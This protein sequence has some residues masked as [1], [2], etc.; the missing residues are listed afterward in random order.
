MWERTVS[1]K[2]GDCAESLCRCELFED[3]FSVSFA[4][5]N[6]MNDQP[7]E[8]SFLT[9]WKFWLRSAFFLIVL[10]LLGL[11]LSARQSVATQLAQL[12]AAGLPTNATELNDFY[13]V[14]DGKVDSKRLWLKAVRAVASGNLLERGKDL[15][16]I[17]HGSATVP[18]PG[19]DWEQ[20]SDAE[21]FI[22]GVSQELELIH[23]AADA[24][25]IV[26]FPVDFTQGLNTL[27]VDTQAARDVARLLQ[28]DAYV[29]A[30]QGD[31]NRVLRD[32]LA[33][34]ALSE[35]LQAEPCVISQ[36]I[37]ASVFAM[38]AESAGTML[39]LMDWNDQQLSE[40]QTVVESI[41]FREG[42][43]RA[44]CGE[45]ATFLD[46]LGQFPLGPFRNAATRDALEY[47]QR[48]VESFQ[49]DWLETIECHRL[50]AQE[51]KEDSQTTIGRYKNIAIAMMFP[52]S[53]SFA[54]SGARS[55]SRQ[56]YLLAAICLQRHRLRHGEFPQ[57]LQQ[58][59]VDLLPADIATSGFVDHFTGE[60]LKYLIGDTSV[61]VYTVGQNRTDDGGAIE[62]DE[63]RRQQLDFGIELKITTP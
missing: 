8:A 39:S 56:Q 1:R 19:Q 50:I 61:K 60:S 9:S 51:I 12:R 41:D 5:G 2:R 30:H 37:R 49:N 24:G 29:A 45:R 6:I 20:Y 28:L 23:F 11:W 42:Y 46:S 31:R 27:L 48:S 21:T 33:M 40:L 7:P 44:A 35:A 3:D 32:V 13:A 38:A 54:V 17:G 59:D 62:Y 47:F 55:Q 36:L 57:S 22:S 15:P 26:R 4:T 52:A 34:L 43:Y 18:D 63:D 58:I 25:G 14:P 10:V 16:I 53:L